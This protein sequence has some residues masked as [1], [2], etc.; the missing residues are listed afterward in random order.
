LITNPD[1]FAFVAAH[2][3]HD[4]AKLALSGS[5]YPHLR[6]AAA[7]VAARQ[8]ARAKLPQWAACPLVW[9]PGS[10]AL[11]QCSSEAAARYKADLVQ[12][13]ALADLT[14]GLGVDTRYF[15]GRFAQVHYVERQPALAEAA[16]WNLAQLGVPNVAVHH[17]AAED[18]L[19]HLPQ[20]IDCFYLDPARRA[21][22][23]RVFQLQDCEPD[24]AAWLPRL[25]ALA[26]QVLLKTS[27]LLDLA[28]ARRQ[29][30][31]AVPG[32]LAQV[33]VLAVDND[34]KEVLYLLNRPGAAPA[35][36]PT[37]RAVNLGRPGTTEFAFTL[38]QEQAATA[39]L[40]P[41]ENYLYEPNPA[42]LKAGAFKSVAVGYGLTKLHPHTHLYTSALAVPDFPGRRFRLKAQIKPDKRALKE[43]IPAGRANLAVRNFPQTVAQLRQQLALREGGD[44]YLFAC[45]LADGR[46]VILVTEPG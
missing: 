38:A 28:A 40:G 39:P 29:L 30:H 18:F 31:L 3:A 44:E 11:E 1:F 42:V 24:A 20:P 26:P 23:G 9:F 12:G 10:L 6:E 27:P 15:A 2:Q 5:P 19:A 13:R 45:T 33:V 46:K 8:K 35:P 21:E 16:A 34:C 7:Q 22:Q 37:V 25:L 43:L 14:G 17:Q 36:E 41:P 32:A 4:P